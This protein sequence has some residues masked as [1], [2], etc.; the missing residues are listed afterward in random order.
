MVEVSFKK[1]GH[2]ITFI[3]AIILLAASKK[4][5]LG[6]PLLGGSILLIFALLYIFFARLMS[7]GLFVYPATILYTI[8]YFLF[9]YKI[10]SMPPLLPLLT[11][12]LHRISWHFF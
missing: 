9:F 5:L 10:T 4:F 7:T 11:I 2:M 8:S 12:P 1:I 3:L 6:N